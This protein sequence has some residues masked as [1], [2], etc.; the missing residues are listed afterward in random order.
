MKS[1]II[2]SIGTLGFSSVVIYGLI[3]FTPDT[4]EQWGIALSILFITLFMGIFFL[5]LYR[6]EKKNEIQSKPGVE[7]E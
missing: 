7:H 5:Y 2:A 4:W 1:L 3:F 6:T